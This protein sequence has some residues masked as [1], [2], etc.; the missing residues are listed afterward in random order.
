MTLKD[1]LSYLWDEYQ[2][3][4]D[5][6]WRI[7]L[8]LTF[9]VALLSIIPY[10][11]GSLSTKI[12]AL[13]LVPPGL[14]VVLAIFGSAVIA[15]EYELFL[16]IKNA[17]RCLQGEFFTATFGH[18]KNCNVPQY[19]KRHLFGPFLVLYLF[20]LVGLALANFIIMGWK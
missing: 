16:T 15:N 9:V 20:S 14:A 1:E 3:R 17:Y 2:Y 11:N 5:L 19:P 6:V 4:H 10:A 13:M 8:R 12:G 18:R 7:T